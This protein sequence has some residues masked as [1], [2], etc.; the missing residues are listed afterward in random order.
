[1]P[2][3]IAKIESRQGLLHLNTIASVSDA[4]LVDRGDLSR[5]VR[6][7][8]IPG[9]VNSIVRTCRDVDVPC[10]IATNVLDSMMSDS[11]PRG[12]KFPIFIIFY[13]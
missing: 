4:I 10:Y 6:I 3:I 7:S 13:L 12:L 11:L 1:M 8:M 5:E 2:K 9:I